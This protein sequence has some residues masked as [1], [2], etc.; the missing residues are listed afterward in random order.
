M[1]VNEYFD[2]VKN[3][4]GESFRISKNGNIIYVDANKGSLVEKSFTLFDVVNIFRSIGSAFNIYK[5]ELRIQYGDEGG[6]YYGSG[7]VNFLENDGIHLLIDGGVDNVKTMNVADLCGAC[8][9][10]DDINVDLWIKN[11]DGGGDYFGYRDCTY[12][13]I[14]FEN[15]I[16]TLG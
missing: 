6:E 9:E 16:I 4:L 8:D 11:M 5:Y 10:Y 3:I 15:K 12:F 7:E 1:M 13:G 14:D 2:K